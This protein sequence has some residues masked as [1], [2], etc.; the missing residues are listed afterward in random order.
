MDNRIE[1]TRQSIAKAFVEL[2]S[3]KPLERITVKEL[4]ELAQI[5]KSTFYCHYVDIYDLSEKVEQHIVSDIMKDLDNIEDVIQDPAEFSGR[6][7]SEYTKDP[8]V[9][10]IFS[11]SR[12]E[13]FPRKL[14]ASIKEHFFAR[15]PEFANSPEKNI[16]L[17]YCVYGSYYTLHENQEYDDSTAV[18]IICEIS[19]RIVS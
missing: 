14:L 10:I 15:F 4:C 7:F 16:M 9:K 1:K 11:D 3:H 17:T 12:R 18:K 2:R 6:L 19:K 13:Q 5:N 8:L